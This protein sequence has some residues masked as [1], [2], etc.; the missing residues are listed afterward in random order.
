MTE[1]IENMFHSKN[2]RLY[3]NFGL[4]IIIGRVD[5]EDKTTK[6]SGC[7]RE[8]FGSGEDLVAFE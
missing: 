1:H 4:E 8:S 7:V 6:G 2:W 5:L 3:T